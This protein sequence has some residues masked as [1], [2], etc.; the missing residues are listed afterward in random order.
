MRRHSL[1]VPSLDE[2]DNGDLVAE[3][4]SR[5]RRVCEVQTPRLVSWGQLLICEIL[6]IEIVLRHSG[7]DEL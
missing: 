3:Y 2:A 5:W 6:S 4:L 1:P 7:G